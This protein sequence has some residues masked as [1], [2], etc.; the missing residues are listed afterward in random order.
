MNVQRVRFYMPENVP[1]Q[2]REQVKVRNEVTLSDKTLSALFKVNSPD[3]NDIQFLQGEA[4]IKAQHPSWTKEE[5]EL[6]FGRK[7]RTV[8]K[9]VNHGQQQSDLATKL[10]GLKHLTTQLAGDAKDDANILSSV[11]NI[12]KTEHKAFKTPEVKRQ[13]Q[14]ALDTLDLPPLSHEAGLPR[15]VDK[16]DESVMAFLL[17][18]T[19]NDFPYVDDDGEMLPVNFHLNDRLQNGR[20]LD[21]DLLEITNRQPNRPSLRQQITGYVDRE[22]RKVPNEGYYDPDGDESSYDPDEDY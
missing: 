7:Q 14:S 11:M 22:E 12:I 6:H 20:T 5:I 9:T 19:N 15:F 8:T 13:V 17:A 4:A 10:A 3:P 1:R 18:K 2:T 21:L 16:I